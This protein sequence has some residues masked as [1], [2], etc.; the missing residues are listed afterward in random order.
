MS[1]DLVAE[2][3]DNC[4]STVSYVVSRFLA[5]SLLPVRKTQASSLIAQCDLHA[6]V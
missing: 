2:R 5:F 4:V 3:L 1:S 6:F